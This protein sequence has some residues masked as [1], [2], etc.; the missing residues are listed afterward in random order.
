MF[1]STLPFDA[2]DL[3]RASA[4]QR[5]LQELQRAGD[6]D[7]G[8]SRLASLSPSLMQDL[9]RFEHS[10]R[11][12]EGLEVLEVL[13]A[14]VRH[15]RGLLV[16]LQDD[17]RVLPL[18]VFPTERLVHCPMRMDQLLDTRLTEL[19]VMHVEPAVLKAPGHHDTALVADPALYAPLGPLLWELALRGARE[20]LLPE[21]SGMAAY[22]I[23]PGVDLRGMHLNGTM[24]AAVVRLK[25]ATTNLREIA[26]WPGF[27]R[28]RATR[29]LNALYLQSGLM[30]SRT[31]PAATND[32]WFSG[33]R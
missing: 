2:P 20:D 5:Y 22:R 14:C 9:Q 6:T 19:R 26:E 18:T 11:P 24:A 7:G 33:S 27:D 16:H 23:A 25:R 4:F 3:M 21:I 10:R 15:G 8:R 30:V 32:G 31:H 13:A 12:G 29:L 28:A 1:Q 17:N